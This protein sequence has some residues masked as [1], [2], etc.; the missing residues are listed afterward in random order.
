MYANSVAHARIT[1]TVR[2]RGKMC[3]RIGIHLHVAG[4]LALALQQKLSVD[5]LE[6]MSTPRTDLAKNRISASVL[7]GRL[8][9]CHEVRFNWKLLPPTLEMVRIHI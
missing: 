8:T 5:K 1:R 3:A 7:S 6:D 4:L 9:Q 2:G